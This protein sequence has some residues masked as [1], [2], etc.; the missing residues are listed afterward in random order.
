MY[1]NSINI[2]KKKEIRKKE[3]YNIKSKQY[4]FQVSTYEREEAYL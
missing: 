2:S 1:E 3:N 4:D